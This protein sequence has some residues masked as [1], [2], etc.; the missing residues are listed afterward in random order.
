MTEPVPPDGLRPVRVGLL[1]AGYVGRALIEYLRQD[2][3]FR[4]DFV[5][6][7]DPGRVPAGVTAIPPGRLVHHLDGVDVVVEAAHPSLT[8]DYGLSIARACDYLMMSTSA[9]VDDALRTGLTRAAE[10]A[11]HR[12]LLPHGALVGLESLLAGQW[13][14]VEITFVKNPVHIEDASGRPLAAGLEGTLYR[15][16]VRGIAERYPRNINSMVTLALATTGLDDCTAH[17]IARPGAD[18]AELQIQAVGPDGS[19][20]RIHK[21]QPMSGVSGTEMIASTLQS[22]LVTTGVRPAGLSFV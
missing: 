14:G 19:S 6:V 21:S 9:L 5:C 20:L 7:R 4:L 15:G 3:R 11:G 13:A 16:P 12:L 10:Q 2:K 17:L 1:G 8:V 22:L 18:S